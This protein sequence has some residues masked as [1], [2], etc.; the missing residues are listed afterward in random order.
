MDSSTIEVLGIIAG[1]LTTGS[2]VP[3]AIKIL[4]TRDVSGIS[5]LMYIV[6]AI[7]LTLWTVYGCLNGQISIIAANG[8]T[9]ALV[10]IILVMKIRY[11]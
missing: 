1:C 9:L 10:L 2:F 11:H 4:K 6:L 7:G 3:Q 8:V 5:L